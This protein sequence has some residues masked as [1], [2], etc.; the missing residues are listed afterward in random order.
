MFYGKINSKMTTLV[1]IVSLSLSDCL[2]SFKH[3]VAFISI[4]GR[5][6]NHTMFGLRLSDAT[7][8][9]GSV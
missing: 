3:P 2:H 4:R 9:H 7:P 8:S 6:S 1:C 5:D